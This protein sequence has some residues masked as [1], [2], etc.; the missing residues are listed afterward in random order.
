MGREVIIIVLNSESLEAR[1]KDAEALFR[2]SRK[3]I[4]AF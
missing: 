4:R 2:W 3:K 1:Y